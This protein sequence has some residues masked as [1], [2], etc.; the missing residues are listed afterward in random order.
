VVAQSTN[1]KMAIFF[2]AAMEARLDELL[3]YYFFFALFGKQSLLDM[4]RT[5]AQYIE[6]E[7]IRGK[8]TE[9]CCDCCAPELNGIP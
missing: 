9:I 7:T 8:L 2:A 6:R 4:C 5:R 1:T 3:V